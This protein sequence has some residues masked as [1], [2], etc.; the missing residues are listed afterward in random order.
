MASSGFRQFESEDQRQAA[1]R[2]ASRHLQK[3][4]NG[5]GSSVPFG[6]ARPST[7][8]EQTLAAEPGTRAREKTQV[9]FL[10]RWNKQKG[11][12]SQVHDHDH[13]HEFMITITITSS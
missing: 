6:E 4:H 13:D 11:S 5:V 12:R 2:E 9:P 3:Q 1:V 10:R 7:H 8:T